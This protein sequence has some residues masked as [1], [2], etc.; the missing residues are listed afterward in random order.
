LE[1]VQAEGV[2]LER[3]AMGEG[4]G[5]KTLPVIEVDK[6]NEK[7]DGVARPEI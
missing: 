7:K 6:E 3:K 5:L 1:S 2:V 4:T